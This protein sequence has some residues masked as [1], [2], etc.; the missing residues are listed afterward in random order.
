[1][2]KYLFITSLIILSNSCDVVEGPYITDSD[3]Y[4][5]PEKNVLIEDFTGHL[6]SNCPQAAREISAIHDVYGDQIIALAI[7]TSTSFARPYLASQ[8]GFQYDFR[9]TWGEAWDNTFGASAIGLPRGMVNR[10]GGQSPTLSKDEWAEVVADE[11]KKEVDFKITISS[12][13]SSITMTVESQK[14]SSGTYN[15]V[16]CLAESNIINWQKDG[17]LN[18]EDYEHNHVLRCVLADNN[19]SS[20]ST[21]SSGQIIEREIEYTLTDLQQFNIDYSSQT[22]EAGNGNAGNWNAENISIIAFIYNTN[23]NEILQVEEVDLN[24]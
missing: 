24:N 16:I 2:K 12:D 15:Y 11:L 4:V 14:N 5:N 21:F 19:L 17:S 18:V 8:T 20:S 23:T 1:M 13:A 6:C 7:H 9:T 10:I 3:S 22:A